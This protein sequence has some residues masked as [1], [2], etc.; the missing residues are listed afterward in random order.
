MPS[1]C[2][3][4]GNG[5]FVNITHRYIPMPE[6]GVALPYIGVQWQD[7]LKENGQYD[8]P[9]KHKTPISGSE[10]QCTSRHRTKL[11]IG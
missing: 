1:D 6:N 2:D 8:P 4:G 3:L 10:S 11:E 7:N 5:S 9:A